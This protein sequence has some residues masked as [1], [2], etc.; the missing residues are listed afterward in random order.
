MT[1]CFELMI[2]K[3]VKEILLAVLHFKIN[4]VWNFLEQE[5]IIDESFKGKAFESRI[6]FQGIYESTSP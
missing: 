1:I 2:F 5:L 4:L 3:K 6:I